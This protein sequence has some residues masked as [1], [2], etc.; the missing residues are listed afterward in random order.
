MSDWHA[1]T[2]EEVLDILKTSRA[3]LESKDAEQRLKTYGY[4]EIVKKKKETY[5]HV[6]IRQF[7]SP[8][9]YVLIFAAVIAFSLGKYF[10]TAVIVA[11][12]TVNSVI[13]TIQEGRAER[14]IAALKELA[15]PRSKVKRDGVVNEIPSKLIVPG[16]VI[17]F[18]QGDKIPATARILFAVNLKMDEAML[19]GE[20]HPVEKSIEPLPDETPLHDRANMIFHGSIVLEGRGE[21]VVVATGMATELGRIAELVEE[22]REDIPIIRRLAKFSRWIIS[23][24]FVLMTTTVAIGL[25][26]ALDL[27]ELFLVALSQAVSAVPE[28]LPVAITV[29]LSVGM[30]RMARRNVIIRRMAAIETLGSINT[31][32]TDKTGTLTKNEMTLTHAFIGFREY[33]FTGVGYSPEGE[34][35]GEV[36]NQDLETALTVG[37]LCN[38]AK[39]VR[40]D[41]GW[42]VYGDPT[43]GALVVAA[44]K[45]GLDVEKLHETYPRV[46]EIPF[47]SK[48]RMMA[49]M[50]KVGDKSRVLV[51]GAFERLCELS[52]YVS[53]GGRVRRLTNED[54]VRLTK[55]TQDFGANALRVLALA[56]AEF[57][58][59]TVSIRVDQL[60]Q[61]L[62]LV[63]VVGMIDPPRQE[64]IEAVRKCY[65]AGVEPIMVTGDNLATA[66]AVAKMLGMKNPRGVQEIEKIS[67]E[68]LARLDVNVYARVLPEH[69]LRIVRVLKDR[70][71]II[72]MT[73]D[74]INDAP[75]LAEANV[76][77][78]MGIK[79]TDAAKDASHVILTDDN[80]ASIVNGVEEGRGI[81]E[82]L[83]KLVFFL[84]STNFGEI[85]TLLTALAL[86]L[87][88]PLVAAQILW[89]NM[90][91]DGVVAIPLVMDP[92][93]PGLL[94][95]PPPPY[96][97][98][99]L[100]RW[101]FLRILI[102]SLTM[103][104][105]ALLVFNHYLNKTNY[106]YAKTMVFTTLVILQW[107]NAFNSRSFEGSAFRINPL[108]NFKLIV[109]IFMGIVLQLTAIY[110]PLLQ[111]FLRTTPLQPED[112]LAAVVASS[113]VLWVMELFKLMVGMRRHG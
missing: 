28:G 63:G 105:T 37:A 65:E 95:R 6:F 98:P 18:E 112:L 66:L 9:I 10:D 56:Y 103:S 40:E 27:Y 41:N 42:R 19:T 77:I 109:G 21:A 83:K 85:I 97:E 1:K 33:V 13:G 64:A 79:G 69:K 52:G 26:R 59:D 24:V 101:V 47:D 89:I 60:K 20:S 68:E 35:I 107:F 78:A 90:V 93:E 32:C 29:A 80:F 88:L 108:T 84:I 39:L 12:L 58:G 17:V 99:F 91:T 14:S 8:I 31:I 5:F 70:G 113:T 54:I 38:N 7:K 73:G 74:G 106:E 76:G 94:K 102:V 72:A 81:R 75:A 23:V 104:A 43:E 61:K 51:K 96:D 82:N 22:A 55:I 48:L 45:A 110:V 44:Y 62:V 15:A 67:D 111:P 71:R 25:L 46:F 11:I 87:P 86:G 16:D 2:V 3:G 100:P 49:T 53:D 92:K 34:I 57:D 50:H 4:N 30:Y 36:E